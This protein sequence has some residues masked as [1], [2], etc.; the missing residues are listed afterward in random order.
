MAPCQMLI[1]KDDATFFFI[2]KC[3]PQELNSYYRETL[4][5]HTTCVRESYLIQESCSNTEDK[6][7]TSPFL[8]MFGRN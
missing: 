6:N 7:F 2:R 4:E 1:D 5:I 3:M 8:K